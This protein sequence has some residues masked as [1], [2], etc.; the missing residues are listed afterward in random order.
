MAINFPVSPTIDQ[1]FSSSGNT[2]VW[3]GYYWKSRGAG[4]G[5]LN[6]PTN[7]QVRRQ[8]FTADGVSA[9]YTLTLTPSSATNLLVYVGGIEQSADTVTLSGNVVTLS[10]TPAAGIV[11]EI[12]DFSS[13]ATLG[14][15]NRAVQ[16]FTATANQTIV[17]SAVAYSPAL[18]DVYLNGLL[19]NSTQYTATD[20]STVVMTYPMA[21]G[22]QVRLVTYTTVASNPV[23]FV[24]KK[25]SFV[26]TRSTSTFT[27]TDGYPVGY[28][29]VYLNGSRLVNGY[30]Y[31]ATDALKVVLTYPA[32]SGD[33]VETQSYFTS[34]NTIATG[35]TGSTGSIGSVGYTGSTGFIGSF[36][37]A[38]SLGY[39]GSTGARGPSGGYTGSIGY[40]G[41]QGPPNGYTGSSGFI[42]S[43][44]YTGSA[45]SLPTQTGNSGLYLTTNG[46][47]ASWA[48]VSALPAQSGN[49]G[50]FLST[51]G[52]APFWSQVLPSQS[53]NSGLYLTTNGSTLSWGIVNSLPLQTNNTG[54][55][56]TTDGVS[57]Q[58]AV[59][60]ITP[61][62]VSN[63]QNTSTGA[64]NFPVGTT[65][66]RPS[67][68]FTGYT[69]VNTDTNYLEIY[70]NNA[71]SNLTYIGNSSGTG[72]NQILTVGNFK[73]HVFTSSGNFTYTAGPGSSVEY[74]IIGGGGGGGSDMGGG[75][76]AGG[77]LAGTYTLATGSYTVTVGGGGNGAPA[78]VSQPAG[79]AGTNSSMAGIPLTAYGGGGGGS[80]YGSTSFSAPN[81]YASGGGAAGNTQ[82]GGNAIA[83]QGNPGGAGGGSY[84][85]GGGGGAGYA[86]SAGQTNGGIG[87]A[88]VL[89]G[90]LGI[91]YYWAAGGGGAGYSN[92][93][94]NGGIGG[95]G[96]GAPYAIGGSNGTTYGGLGGGTAFNVGLQGTAGSLV[97]QTNVPGGAAGA[98]TGSGGGGGAHYNSNNYGGNGGSGIVVIRYRFQ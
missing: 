78:G 18:L 94:G 45:A 46:T 33:V 20:G 74:M 9:S 97:S 34:T 6:V 29:D 2:W 28:I 66:Q 75:G 52:S 98:N 5:T 96:G 4:T 59:V 26:L 64:F 10:A 95:G 37:Y 40:A 44:G 86:G 23:G 22:D 16:N 24:I 63:Q 71:W 56:L 93:A 1:T 77:Y 55:F 81:G 41:S 58:W 54:K 79:S 14:A 80:E 47:L 32:A 35:Y 13:G 85:P 87:G 57:A 62:A 60:S 31:T 25:Q 11:V 17:T 83:G 15:I 7:Y 68:A 51:S 73:V 76:G 65:A 70:Y 82:P 84:Y 53:G 8:K 48:A 3:T 36:G 27:I 89:N 61:A 92:I 43:T 88:G 30:D 50:L 12:V 38:G 49:A 91:S 90:I 67:T 72:G 42:G 39:T 21:V 69:R 19:L